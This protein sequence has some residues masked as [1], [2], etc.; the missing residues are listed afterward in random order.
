M[1]FLPTSS[2]VLLLDEKLLVDS[3][4]FLLLDFQRFFLNA[5]RNSY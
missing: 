1:T 5:Y 4:Y 3:I 2:I